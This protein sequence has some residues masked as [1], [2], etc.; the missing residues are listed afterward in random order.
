MKTKPFRVT[1]TEVLL[2]MGLVQVQ[3]RLRRNT[4]VSTLHAPPKQGQILYSSLQNN[5]IQVLQH[6]SH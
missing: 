2:L 1:L 5:D 4:V 3:L 6:S